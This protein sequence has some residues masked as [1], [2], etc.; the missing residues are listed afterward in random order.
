MPC[1]RG[2]AGVVRA[3]EVAPVGEGRPDLR[4]RPRI[5]PHCHT[6]GLLRD[7]AVGEC[8]GCPDSGVVVHVRRGVDHPGF[9][10]VGLDDLDVRADG[11]VDETPRLG[12]V[13]VRVCVRDRRAGFDYGDH[14]GFDGCAIRAAQTMEQLAHRARRDDTFLRGFG[15]GFVPVLK[16]ACSWPAILRRGHVGLRRFRRFG[17]ELRSTSAH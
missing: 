12:Q 4:Q 10:P 15:R 8:D 2:L 16:P 7:S 9:D 11:E 13:R 5:H 1:S 3:G 14:A 6:R 17:L